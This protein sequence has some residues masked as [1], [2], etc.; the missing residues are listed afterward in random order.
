M[1]M[2][3]QDELRTKHQQAMEI[4]RGIAWEEK[5]ARILIKEQRL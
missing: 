5:K 2:I 4:S 1:N 3:S